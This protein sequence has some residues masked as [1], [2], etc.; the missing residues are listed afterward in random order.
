MEF[1]AGLLIF[2]LI[3]WGLWLL[4][5]FLWQVILYILCAG[6]FVA[7]FYGLHCLI[8][9][10]IKHWP[11]FQIYFADS[12]RKSK[13]MF[14]KFSVNPHLKKFARLTFHLDGN[15]YSALK[16]YFKV[17]SIDLENANKFLESCK[18]IAF[19]EAFAKHQLLGGTLN[20]SEISKLIVE[21]ERSEQIL[22]CAYDILKEY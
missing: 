11:K 2:G 7:L 4:L 5:C 16:N 9:L 21:T 20:F 10:L 14:D 19:L 8:E 13:K 17:M 1:I 22:S 3:L 6:A 18:G 15:Q 12:K